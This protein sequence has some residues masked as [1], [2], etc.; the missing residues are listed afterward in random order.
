VTLE[1]LATRLGVTERQLR[2]KD[3]CTIVA[4]CGIRGMVKSADDG[5]LVVV[6]RSNADPLARHQLIDA[7]VI[8]TLHG[9]AGLYR[10]QR[11]PNG[12]VERQLFCELLGLIGSR[13]EVA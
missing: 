12:I 7:N 1:K 11:L 9:D 8:A 6:L 4:I 3:Q 10:L 13:R 5:N 2:L